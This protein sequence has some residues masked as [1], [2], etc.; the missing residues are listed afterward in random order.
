MSENAMSTFWLVVLGTVSGAGAGLLAG[1]IGIGG[2]IV[3]VPVIFYGLVETGAPADQAA[4]VAVGTSLAAILPAAI[5][6]SLAHWRTGNT[7]LRFLRDWGPG[8]ATG[9]VIAQLAA[10][11]V[12]GAVMTGAFALLCLTFAARFAFP[13]RFG[14]ILQRPPAGGFG[15][16]A[17]AAIGLSS[18]LAGVGGGILTNIVMALSGM[19]MHKSIGRAAAAGVVVSLPATIVAAFATGGTAPTQ[20]GSIDLAVWASVAPTQ[21]VAAW[22]GARLAQRVTGDSLSRIMAVALLATGAVMLH[23]SIAGR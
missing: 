1:L 19:P 23:S 7:D 20:L 21:A 15:S 17:G 9:V 16:I 3:I 6:S 5:V 10:P 22:F 12:R 13:S 8:I 14:P 18:G 2:G 4:H 11:H